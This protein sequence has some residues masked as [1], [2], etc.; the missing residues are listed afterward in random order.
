MALH[1]VYG[2]WRFTE[3]SS[4]MTNIDKSYAA[5]YIV[6]CEL[7]GGDRY[8]R[9]SC[10]SDLLK[11][12]DEDGQSWGCQYGPNKPWMMIG[13]GGEK[14]FEMESTTARY[15]CGWSDPFCYTHNDPRC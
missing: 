1:T 4:W 7:Q 12:T 13:G 3:T 10:V 14:H 15:R 2:E 8:K 5:F 6:R 11:S 9:S